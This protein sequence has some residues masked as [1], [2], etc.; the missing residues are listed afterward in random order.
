MS[1]DKEAIMLR[2]A[3]FF[4][5]F[6]LVYPFYGYALEI[7]REEIL[8]RPSRPYVEHIFLEQELISA[9]FEVTRFD[10]YKNLIPSIFS[11]PEQPLCRVIINNFYKMESAPPYLEAVVQILVKFKRP[12][13]GDE[14]PAWHYLGLSV[15]SEEALWAGLV[16]IPKS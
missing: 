13:S 14:I 15:T 10:E 4:L 11:M 6:L 1:T 7:E 12:Q 5:I 9:Y 3:K 8:Q 16:A 2:H